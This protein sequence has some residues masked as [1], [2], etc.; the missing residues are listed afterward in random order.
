MEITRKLLQQM[1]LE[2]ST[3]QISLAELIISLQVNV[4]CIDQCYV[5]D[6]GGGSGFDH[7]VDPSDGTVILT[8]PE[9]DLTN[10]SH[11]ELS[12]YRWFYNGELN[13]NQ[14]NDQMQVKL[15]NGINT[16]VLETI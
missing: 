8:S 16:I 14:P 15:S 12:Y 11:A 10:Y 3:C 9:F 6:N 5:T 4:D 1:R 13:G 2:I 7:D